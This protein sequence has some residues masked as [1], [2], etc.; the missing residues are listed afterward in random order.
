[1]RAAAGCGA[2]WDVPERVLHT[3]EQVVQRLKIIYI[4]FKGSDGKEEPQ[5]SIIKDIQKLPV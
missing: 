1:M 4:I 5:F 2:R 3:R